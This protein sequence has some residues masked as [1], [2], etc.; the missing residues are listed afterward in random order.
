MT[1]ASHI[2]GVR[3]VA[4][5]VAGGRGVRMA[6]DQKKQYLVLDGIPV[7]VRTL[8]AF[9]A[10]PRVDDIILVVPGTDMGFCQKELMASFE[11]LTPLYWAKGGQTRQESVENGLAVAANFCSNHGKTL[12]LVHDGVRPFVSAALVDACLDKARETGACIPG[13]EISDTVKKVADND[14]IKTTLDRDSLFRAQTPQVFRLDL[15][16]AGFDNARK[17]RFQGTDEASIL[18]HANIP[19]HVVK[20][21]RFNFKLTCPEDLVM[22]RFLLRR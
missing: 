2:D 1:K 19:V 16:L 14:Q 13:L 12:V 18:E 11:P 3:R 4:V 17:T 20:G 9:D 7:L 5:I 22:A 8:M 15:I 6:S 10:H 21:D